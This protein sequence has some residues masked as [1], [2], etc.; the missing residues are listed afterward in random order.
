M[1]CVGN[2]LVK[3]AAKI[4]KEKEN[5]DSQPFKEHKR[6]MLARLKSLVQHSNSLLSS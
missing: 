5:P 3:D 4:P 6:A 2:E 1:S